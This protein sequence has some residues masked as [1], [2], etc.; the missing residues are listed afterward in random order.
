MAIEFISTTVNGVDIRVSSTISSATWRS[1][2]SISE[3]RTCSV[4][5]VGEEKFVV[6][7]SSYCYDDGIWVNAGTCIVNQLTGVTVYSGGYLPMDSLIDELAMGVDTGGEFELRETDRG[8]EI[9]LPIEGGQGAHGFSGITIG[10]LVEADGMMTVA[11]LAAVIVQAT[12]ACSYW[13][14]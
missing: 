14:K 12:N 13:P 5:S 2:A 10:E 1:D 11:E 6:T 4:A 7:D 9:W 8:F 3:S